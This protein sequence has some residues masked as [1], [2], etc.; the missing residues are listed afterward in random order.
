MSHDLTWYNNGSC[1]YDALRCFQQFMCSIYIFKCSP[2]VALRVIGV[3]V[4]HILI[5]TNNS[6]TVYK[7]MLSTIYYIMNMAHLS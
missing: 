4:Y 1:M 2:G 7:L 5:K 3:Y 6:N